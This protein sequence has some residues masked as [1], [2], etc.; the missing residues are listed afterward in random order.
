MLAPFF[1]L[2]PFLAAFCRSCCVC[3]RSW[4]V[5][6]RLGALRVRFRE[7]LGR[8][9]HGFGGPERSFFEVFSHMQACNAKN[10]QYAKPT[11]FPRFLQVFLTSQTFR[12]GRTTTQS[13]SRSL[14]TIASHKDRAKNSFGGRF[15]KD[16][17]RPWASLGRLWGPLGQLLAPVG[18][19]LGVSWARLGPSWPSLCWSVALLSPVLAS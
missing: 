5:L 19:F 1:A 16:L 12:L 6:A 8:L 11:V 14:P 18:H 4:P 7:G 2:G 10:S 13:R 17:G 15:W 3:C 9:G